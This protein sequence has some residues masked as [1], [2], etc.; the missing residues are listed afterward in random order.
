MLPMVTEDTRL[1]QPVGCFFWK[2]VLV[3]VLCAVM[4]IFVCNVSPVR[5]YVSRNCNGRRV[6]V[7]LL[8]GSVKP[9]VSSELWMH[10][11]YALFKHCLF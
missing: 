6:V 3:D 9:L 10:V 4:Q 7:L 5:V 1:C 2:D 8:S 11:T